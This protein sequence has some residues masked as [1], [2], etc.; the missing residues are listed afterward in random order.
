MS[1]AKDEMIT[2]LENNDLYAVYIILK[3]LHVSNDGMH[4]NTCSMI[5]LFIERGSI[6]R[7]C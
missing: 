2:V 3:G 5:Q 4:G 7:N 1:T 6:D